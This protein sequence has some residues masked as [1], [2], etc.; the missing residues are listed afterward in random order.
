[1]KIAVEI[2]IRKLLV[3]AGMALSTWLSIKIGCADCL[4]LV[5]P[6]GIASLIERG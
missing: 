1:M 6:A 3:L 2:D 5:V 4:F